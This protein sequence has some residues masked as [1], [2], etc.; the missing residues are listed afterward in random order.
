MVRDPVANVVYQLGERGFAPRKL[1]HDAWESRCPAHRGS[2]YSLSIT[3]NEFNHV[4]LECRSSENCQHIRIVRALGWTNEHVYAETADWLISRLGR[5]EIH[6]A[7]F[8]KG[9]PATNDEKVTSSAL[10]TNEPDGALPS[11][12]VQASA[13]AIAAAGSQEDVPGGHVPVTHGDVPRTDASGMAAE[14][15]SPGEAADGVMAAP[16]GSTEL[17]A[18]L[19][20]EQEL[21]NLPAL[22]DSNASSI[23]ETGR[24]LEQV[25]PAQ[26]L[27]SLASGARLFRSNDGRFFAQ[28]RVGDRL[29]IFGLK[30]AAFRDW[31]IEGY[32]AYH[33]ESPTP[34]AVRRAVGMLEA[35]ARFKADIPE[36]FIR[37]G[38]HGEGDGSA[39]FID[40]GD[41]SGRA[42]AISDRG[43]FKVDRP[44]VHFRRPAG[45]QPLPMPSRGGSI[46]LLRPYV[47]LTER[48]FRLT[49]TW[50]T[51]VLRPVGPYPILVLTGEQATAKSTL[52]KVLRLLIDPHTCIAL[53]PPTS[54]LNLMATAVNGWLLAYDNISDIPRWMSDALCQLVFGGA[55]SGRALF[56]NDDRSF[57][58]AQRP[59]LLSGIGEFVRWADLKDRCVFLRLPPIPRTRARGE[60]EFW[61]AFH[62]DRPGILGA[63]LDAMVGG[64]RELPSVHLAELPRMA[65][66]AL[67]GEAVGRGLGWEPGTFLSGYNDNRME[68]TLT[69]L[70]DSRLGN[71]LL[72]A[73]SL[74]P[75][76]SGTP[77]ELHARLT[78]LI[79]KRVAASAEWPKTSAKFGSELR[80]LAPQLRIHGVSVGF[81]RRNDG[82]IITLTSERAPIVPPNQIRPEP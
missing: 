59:V 53:N 24:N 33:P 49:V 25:S 21:G 22:P 28:V 1:G 29:E 73:A 75:V 50:L 51:A 10:G 66:Y 65:D 45:H 55:V 37:T 54:T 15:S 48:D 18:R 26:I 6:T 57:I 31:L 35:R 67:W 32:L 5:V 76:W 58:Y 72:K 23:E 8:K 77:A 2:D 39:Y 36:V 69:D 56:T 34:A 79:D 63:V 61:R 42:I 43:W 30:S 17:I 46:D 3:R 82:R 19:P 12:E 78:H 14:Q 20:L 40:L 7:Q 80:R 70:L 16:G 4:V 47:N 9:E 74:I 11:P 68:A 52:V 41:P 38:R 13:D 64:L 44:D 62:T 71:V 60:E 81:E 27:A